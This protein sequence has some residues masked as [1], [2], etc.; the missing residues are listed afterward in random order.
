MVSYTH[1]SCSWKRAEDPET[2]QLK[3]FGFCEYMDAE[4]VLRA[5]RLLNGLKV[6][7]IAPQ[8]STAQTGSSTSSCLYSAGVHS[9]L[10]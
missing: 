4:G 3:G 8:Q 2:R 1:L 5:I 6:R 9:R 10:L 7:Y